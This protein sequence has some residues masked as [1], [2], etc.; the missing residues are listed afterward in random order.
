MIL[1]DKKRNEK[2]KEGRQMFITCNHARNLRQHS[3]WIQWSTSK[4]VCPKLWHD[5]IECNDEWAVCELMQLT[6][7]SLQT[8]NR[9]WKQQRN[10]SSQKIRIVIFM[11]VNGNTFV[12]VSQ[13]LC[14]QSVWSWQKALKVPLWA[15][16]NVLWKRLQQQHSRETDTSQFEQADPKT[17]KRSFYQKSSAY[18]LNFVIMVGDISF[19][20][21]QH[22]VE[23]VVTLTGSSWRWRM[24]QKETNISWQLFSKQ[25]KANS[26][27]RTSLKSLISVRRF[28]FFL[29]SLASF[30]TKATRFL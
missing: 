3:H 16:V 26:S 1:I 28:G 9:H 8:T 24:L 10:E 18:Q 20:R 23:T 6:P 2:R 25:K 14:W 12:L 19:M 4:Q 29:C 30:A 7:Q 21:G 11:K 17:R 5:E 22:F 15:H 27:L 13:L